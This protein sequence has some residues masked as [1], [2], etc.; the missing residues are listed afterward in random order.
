MADYEDTDTESEFYCSSS[1]GGYSEDDDTDR[2]DGETQPY[3]FEPVV[4]QER[5]AERRTAAANP[6]PDPENGLFQKISVPPL[7]KAFFF[8][9]G[10]YFHLS[11]GVLS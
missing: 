10:G 2:S 9:Q 3:Q 11:R 6:E 7:W 1:S 4:S 8:V 5:L